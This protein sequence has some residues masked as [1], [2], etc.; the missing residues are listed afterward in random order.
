[1]NI[2]LYIDETFFCAFN[3]LM[4]TYIHDDIKQIGCCENSCDGYNDSKKHPC[5]NMNSMSKHN[6]A[7]CNMHIWWQIY[8]IWM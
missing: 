1:M 3:Y 2:K 7:Y 8:I 5:M 4:D 6:Y